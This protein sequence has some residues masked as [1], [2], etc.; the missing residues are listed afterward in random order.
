M[1]YIGWLD[2]FEGRIGTG[3]EETTESELIRELNSLGAVPI[4][5][6]S[7]LSLWK[8]CLQLLTLE[9]D[10]RQAWCRVSGYVDF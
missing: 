9:F 6:V 7:I 3:K 1:A 5:K 4:A 2:T 8:G 10:K